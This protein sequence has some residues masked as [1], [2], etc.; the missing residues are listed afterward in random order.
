VYQIAVADTA[1]SGPSA[2]ETL[3]FSYDDTSS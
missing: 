3:A 1:S 2:D